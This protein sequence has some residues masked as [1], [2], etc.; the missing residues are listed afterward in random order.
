MGAAYDFLKDHTL[1]RYMRSVLG[2]H[3]SREGLDA[4][5]G[6][7]N[8]LVRQILGE[9]AE[10]TR[11]RGRKT[12]LAAA[13]REALEHHL[14]RESLRWED[15]A[16]QITRQSSADVGKIARRLYQRIEELEEAKIRERREEEPGQTG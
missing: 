14:G 16:D 2:L 3:P 1:K 7:V 5:N 12:I 6:T 4:L 8:E 15:V 13:T 10:R 11:A 9:A